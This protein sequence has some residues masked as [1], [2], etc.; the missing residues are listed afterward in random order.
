MDNVFSTSYIITSIKK[1][2]PCVLFV[3]LFF[4]S[5]NSTFIILGKYAYIEASL[6][7]EN[8]TAQLGSPTI[9]ATVSGYTSVTPCSVTFWYHMYGSHIGTLNVHTATT[10]GVPEKTVWS[11]SG[12][13]GNVWKKGQA[14]LMSPKDFQVRIK[15]YLRNRPK[16]IFKISNFEH[17]K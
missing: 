15:T 9:A 6:K 1:T 12:D 11:L 5:L 16:I 13:Q 7:Q 10:Y 2:V 17:K 14:S 4:C 3:L 8:D